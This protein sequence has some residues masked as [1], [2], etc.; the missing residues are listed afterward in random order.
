MSDEVLDRVVCVWLH[1]PSVTGSI[2]TSR[3]KRPAPVG[4][5]T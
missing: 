5:G 3:D 1:N 4:E 2:M